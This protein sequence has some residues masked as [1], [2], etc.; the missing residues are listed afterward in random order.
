MSP[1]KFQRD[2]DRSEPTDQS[3]ESNPVISHCRFPEAVLSTDDLHQV[4]GTFRGN[5]TRLLTETV[6]VFRWK[7]SR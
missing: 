7:M 6:R 2:G 4:N 1:T 5:F 3:P